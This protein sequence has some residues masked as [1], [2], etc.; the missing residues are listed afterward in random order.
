MLRKIIL[1]VVTFVTVG[2]LSGCTVEKSS[3]NAANAACPSDSFLT[4]FNRKPGAII[5]GVLID[6]NTG[7]RVSL[8]NLSGNDGVFVLVGGE[9]IRATPLATG[10][11]ARLDGEY[12]ICDVPFD[13]AY[14]VFALVSGYLPFHGTIQVASALQS[15]ANNA[16]AIAEGNIRLFPLGSETRDFQLRVVNSGAGVANA[17]VRLD[18]IADAAGAGNDSIIGKGGTFLRPSDARMISLTASTNAEGVATFA[19][20]NIVLGGRY[21]F[22]ITPRADANLNGSIS[23]IF[24][25]GIDTPAAGNLGTAASARNGFEF[26]VDLASEAAAIRLVSCSLETKNY[27]AEG[28]IKYLFNQPVEIVTIDNVTATLG[29]GTGASILATNT[30]GN[31]ASEQ[32]TIAGDG[33]NSLTLKPNF[34]TAPSAATE[35]N[36]TVTFDNVRLRPAGDK[37]LA[38]DTLAN[39]I[40][41]AGKCDDEVRFYK[42]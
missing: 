28:S 1:P 6:A 13:N 24:N 35:P 36:L 2:L 31:S 33:T 29:G 23:G 9:K 25:M 20:A 11:D 8:Q 4:G 38:G 27:D 40:A 10:G 16:R 3:H 5:Q 12:Y 39:Y 42:N 32:V 34:A 26:T 30:A 18:P 37:T 21:R 7:K 41:A 14:P 15:T 22:M 19:A 17:T